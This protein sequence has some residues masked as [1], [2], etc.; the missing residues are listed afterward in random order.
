MLISIHKLGEV[1]I[2]SNL[3]GSLSLTSGQREV[4][5]ETMASVNSR[6][7]EVTKNDI[8]GMQDITIPN[9]I[10]EATKL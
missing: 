5:N 1:G 4:D 8:L 9:D 2:S 3:I 7:A 6:F 10:K